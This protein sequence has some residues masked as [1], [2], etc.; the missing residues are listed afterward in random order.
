MQIEPID[1]RLPSKVPTWLWYANGLLFVL[2]LALVFMPGA[3]RNEASADSAFN[4]NKLVAAAPPLAVSPQS[5]PEVKPLVLDWDAVLT[6]LEKTQVDGVAVDGFTID[7]PRRT[8]RLTLSFDTYEH[9]AQY[10]AS[11]HLRSTQLLCQ[12]DSAEMANEAGSAG[13]LGKAILQ[14]E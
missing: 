8:M 10:M 4:A 1:L 7:A 9:L 11:P 14:C 12:L 6:G 3:W 2:L 13:L 5:A